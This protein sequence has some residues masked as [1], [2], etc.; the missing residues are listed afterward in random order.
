VSR[1]FPLDWQELKE[2]R[3]ESDDHQCVDCGREAPLWVAPIAGNTWGLEDLRTV[4]DR[5]C[6][7]EWQEPGTKVAW[8]DRTS[9]AHRDSPQ[10]DRARSATG[11][12]IDQPDITDLFFAGVPS[13]WPPIRSLLT[14]FV[15]ALSL[16]VGATLLY[17]EATGIPTPGT[18]DGVPIITSVVVTAYLVSC[19]GLVYLQVQHRDWLTACGTGVC[20]IGYAVSSVAATRV[21]T[22]IAL[23]G[24]TIVTAADYLLALRR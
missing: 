24:L 5:H 14:A 1:D 15:A 21:E 20:L 18:P 19:V 11:H 22:G 4:C 13:R 16:Y 17:R 3:F 12:S 2:S 7:I 10:R 9:T 6:P 8:E 23:L